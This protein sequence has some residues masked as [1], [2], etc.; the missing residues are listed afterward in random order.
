[1][2]AHEEWSALRDHIDTLNAAAAPVAAWAHHSA[3]FGYANTAAGIVNDEMNGLWEAFSSFLERYR[4]ALPD[5]VEGLQSG[6]QQRR[7]LIRDHSS[8]NNGKVHE[9]VLWQCLFGTIKGQIDRLLSNTEIT[10]KSKTERAFEHLQR[11]IVTDEPTRS[12]WQSAYNTEGEVECECHGGV[13]LLYHGIWG[14]KAYSKGERT[15]LVLGEYLGAELVKRGQETGSVLVLTE[16]K[17]IPKITHARNSPR[18]ARELQ[19]FRDSAT[20]DVEKQVTLY[21]GGSLAAIELHSVCYGIL[22]SWERV[23]VPA[24][25]SLNGYSLRFINIAVNPRSPSEEAA[26]AVGTAGT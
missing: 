15:D 17:K 21:R 7:S 20:G 1:M 23:Q 6:W 25:R 5:E 13:H 9:V 16:W 3:H 24:E 12:K 2:D 14:F 18:Y 11:L 22:V 26:S 4:S 19:S 8:K 10:W